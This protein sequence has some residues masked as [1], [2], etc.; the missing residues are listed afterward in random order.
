MKRIFVLL[1]SIVCCALG[2]VWAVPA[3]PIVKTLIQP[4]GSELKVRL[5]GDENGHYYITNIL[6]ITSI[7]LTMATLIYS[8]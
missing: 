4:D 6:F 1:L 3:K 5:V 8:K 7:N 2:G